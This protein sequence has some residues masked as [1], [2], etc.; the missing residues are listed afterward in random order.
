[1]D[2]TDPL[3]RLPG[4]K[5]TGTIVGARYDASGNLV[6]GQIGQDVSGNIT[7][8]TPKNKVSVNAIYTFDL[9]KL[10]SLT[11]SASYSWQD[12]TY[13]SIY[14]RY[15]NR[16]PSWDMT[17]L[18]LLWNSPDRHFSVIGFINN[19][20]DG[21]QYDG[22]T[23]GLRRADAVAAAATPGGTIGATTTARTIPQTMNYCATSAA[24]TIN[25][26][27]NNGNGSLAESCITYSEQYRMPRW[28]GVELQFHF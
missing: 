27:G 8:F 18:R 25:P 13:S 3:A 26:L 14:N 28:G 23:S 15:T 5:P 9:N 10:G 16:T 7:P 17:N 20:F 2:S 21:V 1:V 12:S 22:R 4:A 24:T 6:D 19:I 11:A